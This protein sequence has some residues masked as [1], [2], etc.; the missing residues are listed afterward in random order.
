MRLLLT[1]DL[2]PDIHLFK[3]AAP[4]VAKKAQPGQF[5]VIRIDEKVELFHCRGSHKPKGGL[6]EA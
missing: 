3:I 5:V 6:V 1:E 4:K 2:V